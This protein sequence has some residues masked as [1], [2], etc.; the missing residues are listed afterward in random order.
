M[1]RVR[2]DFVA[3]QR[4]HPGFARQC[5]AYIEFTLQF[6]IA[7]GMLYAGLSGSSW[8]RNQKPL[9]RES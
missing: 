2:R 4:S 1:K 7:W 5:F 9:L 6:A 3:L 8:F